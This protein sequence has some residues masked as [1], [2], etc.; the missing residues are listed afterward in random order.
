[1]IRN[2]IFEKMLVSRLRQFMG[3]VEVFEGSTLAQIC[4]CHDN[5]ISFTVERTG[6][7][8]KFF[9][10]GVSQKL[11][12]KLFDFDRKLDISKKHNL[13][14]EFDIGTDYIYPCPNFFVEDITRDENTNELT[15][16]AYDALYKAS[17]HTVSELELSTPY[18][19]KTVAQACASLL[20]LPATFPL[21]E[22]FDMVYPEGAN[23]DGTETLREA[24]DA[25]AEA[26]QT[27][28]YIDSNW[29]LTFKRLDIAGEPVAIIDKSQYMTLK[30]KD[31]HTLS[32]V[33]HV[34]ELGDNIAAT[35]NI[36]GS[37]QYVRNN[38]FWEL[39]DDI[40]EIV[41]DA[42][43]AVRGLTFTNFDCSW[44]GN[45]LIEIGDKIGFITKDD[46]EI[47]SYL[48]NDSFTFNGGLNGKT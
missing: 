18:T 5:L 22:S 24:L 2:E 9:G 32:N 17:K 8:N 29:E 28:Y 46:Q 42:A 31:T 47:Y 11:T 39:R 37:V 44:R 33:V 27:I 14:V 7:Q 20:G 40:A 45:F 48:L 30:N 38:P 25:I 15:I 4:G 36:E 43:A 1:M 23:F 21:I 13:E 34:T 41:E 19:I 10:F 6:E 35:T 16:V 26:T 12:T 3:R